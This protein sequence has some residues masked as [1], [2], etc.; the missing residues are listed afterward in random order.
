MRADLRAGLVLLEAERAHGSGLGLGGL[1]LAATDADSW[2]IIE[3]DRWSAFYKWLN[4]NKLV[5][6]ELDVNAGWTMD[7]LEA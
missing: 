6:H 1:G 7:Y 2:G 5:K 4:D 3:K